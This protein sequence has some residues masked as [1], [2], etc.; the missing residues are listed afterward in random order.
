MHINP[1]ILNGG[2]NE[3]DFVALFRKTL[4]DAKTG[5]SQAAAYIWWEFPPKHQDAHE[6]SFLKYIAVR[7]SLEHVF[8]KR[9]ISLLQDERLKELTKKKIHL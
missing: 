5:G 6:M 7:L 4:S 1:F 3:N 8:V 2:Q 9:K